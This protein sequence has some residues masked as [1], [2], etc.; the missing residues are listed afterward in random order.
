MAEIT[1]KKLSPSA[2]IVREALRTRE[3]LDAPRTT[4]RTSLVFEAASGVSEVRLPDDVAD[5]VEAA[6]VELSKGHT[7]RLVREDEELT[8]QQAADLLNVSRPFLTK[9]LARGDIPHHRVGTHRRV[10]RSEV[11]SYRELQ[12]ARA[13][14]AMRDMAEQ[15]EE[16]G[17]YD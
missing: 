16:L 12:A 6:I 17:L 10:Y 5:L 11:E 9:L 13:R 15:A 3:Q 14:E 1:L 4:T 2:G 8:T 7:I